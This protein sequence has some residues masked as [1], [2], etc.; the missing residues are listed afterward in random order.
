MSNNYTFDPSTHHMVNNIPTAYFFKKKCGR[1]GPFCFKKADYK[2]DQIFD[3]L[4][5]LEGYRSI[6]SIEAIRKLRNVRRKCYLLEDSAGYLLA[7]EIPRAQDLKITKQVHAAIDAR[8]EV[9]A[10][11]YLGAGKA[12]NIEDINERIFESFYQDITVRPVWGPGRKL[13]IHYREERATTRHVPHIKT[14][15]WMASSTR[16]NLNDWLDTVYK[17]EK[18]DTSYDVNRDF[19]T[20]GVRYLDT[21]GRH[22]H[23]INV[24]GGRVTDYQGMPAHTGPMHSIML[25]NGWGIY[26]MGFDGQLYLGDHT[27]DEFH[28]SSFL[29]GMP[30]RAGGEIAINNGII[31]GLTNKTG[32]YKSRPQELNHVMNTLIRNFVDISNIAVQDPFKKPAHWFTGTDAIEVNCELEK[33]GASTS[34]KPMVV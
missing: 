25:G 4:K 27:V 6:N 15:A 1:T 34:A 18:E 2:V 10:T 5:D 30:V 11:H 28:H 13:D 17:W 8:I 21:Q 29:S 24:Q 7:G 3:A 26:V 31:V 9:V 12:Q 22:Q 16:L 14:S 19:T 33:L 23:S 20:R 32:H